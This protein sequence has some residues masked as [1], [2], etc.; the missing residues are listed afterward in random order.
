MKH[1]SD[2]PRAFRWRSSSRTRAAGCQGVD[3]RGDG[4]IRFV[5][6]HGVEGARGRQEHGG[7]EGRD[8]AAGYQPDAGVETAYLASGVEHGGGVRH[9]VVREAHDL[10]AHVGDGAGEARVSWRRALHVDPVGLVAG[11][12]QCS[13]QHLQPQGRHVGEQHLQRVERQPGGVGQQHTGYVTPSAS[14]QGTQ[15]R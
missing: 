14:R 5:L 3:H 13:R 15:S 9:L 12:P 8:L 7:P 4:P 11:C 2:T 10:G 6:H 1:T